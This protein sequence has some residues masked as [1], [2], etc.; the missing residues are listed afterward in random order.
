MP[1]RRDHTP[2][3]PHPAGQ[4]P[5]PFEK[6]VAEERYSQFVAPI[7]T[8]YL[9]LTNPKP[10]TL[11]DTPTPAL[12]DQPFAGTIEDL[13]FCPA[14]FD[15]L[16]DFVEEDI[17]KKALGWHNSE[18]SVEVFIEVKD[19]KVVDEETFI[20]FENAAVDRPK[21]KMASGL[22]LDWKSVSQPSLPSSSSTATPTSSTATS[23]PL[24]PTRRALRSKAASAPPAVPTIHKSPK[25]RVVQQFEA[26]VGAPCPI[27]TKQTTVDPKQQEPREKRKQ[28][29]LKQWESFGIHDATEQPIPFQHLSLRDQQVLLLYQQLAVQV[30]VMRQRR[31]NAPFLAAMLSTPAHALFL[32]NIEKTFIVGRH[33]SDL[34][35]AS[36]TLNALAYLTI[37]ASRRSLPR[38]DPQ[39]ATLRELGEWFRTL[40]P[41]LRLRGVGS[42]SA[43]SE[44]LTATSTALDGA[45]SLSFSSPCHSP[46]PRHSPSLTL[47]PSSPSSPCPS[48]PSSAPPTPAPSPSSVPP[49]PPSASAPLVSSPPVVLPPVSDSDRSGFPTSRFDFAVQSVPKD[50]SASAAAHLTQTLESAACISVLSSEDELDDIVGIFQRT[51]DAPAST[52]AH[53]MP[54]CSLVLRKWLGSG[55][56][57]DM[58]A[59]ATGVVAA[60]VVRPCAGEQPDEFR[61]RMIAALYE[62][63]L[64]ESLDNQVTGIPRYFGAFIRHSA[65]GPSLILLSQ[66]VPG[67]A[68]DSWAMVRQHRDACLDAVD[69]LHKAGVHHGD[70]R[71]PNM[72]LGYD[73]SITIVDFNRARRNVAPEELEAEYAQFVHDIQHAED[74]ADKTESK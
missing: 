60:K 38:I 3:T 28:P 45:N 20:R 13:R 31:P 62:R 26:I 8:R 30:A 64:L 16:R 24:P 34:S 17:V 61:A 37:Q 1:P 7:N 33:T 66:R 15:N 12:T 10:T 9:D 6:G 23:T 41:V 44:W 4:V 49:A 67:L 59:D 18:G 74:T 63:N 56:V 5:I 27:I 53:T 32:I 21:F 72:I 69:K 68:L 50:Q 57:G 19:V 22:P 65:A 39:T 43:S 55:A 73:S 47:Q 52:P 46:S 40:Q 11:S 29:H 54:E 35:L 42:S 58:Y 14:L 48:P 51:T 70:L 25:S 2:P 71:P 36:R